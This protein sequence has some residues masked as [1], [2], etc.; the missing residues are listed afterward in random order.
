MT[1]DKTRQLAKRFELSV[2][3]KPDSQDI[4]FVPNGRYG[5]VV[6]RLRPGAITPGIIRHLDGRILGEHRGVIDYTIGQRRGL[7]IGGRKE[8][9][10][11][12]SPLYVVN[13][14][15]E[16]HEVIVGPK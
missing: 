14:K 15:P 13:I 4:C 8:D 7:G 11:E 1:K 12:N 2:T 3:Y 6:R 16:V 9:V 10:E 5:D